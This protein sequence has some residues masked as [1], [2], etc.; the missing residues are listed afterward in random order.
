MRPFTF[1]DAALRVDR[2][3]ESLAT[4]KA[5]AS[6]RFARTLS[7]RLTR[8]VAPAEVV[9][10]NSD[11]PR[12]NYWLVTGRVDRM[13]QGSRLLRGLVGF[14]V[15]GTKIET[16]SV[17]SDLSGTNPKPFLVVET[18][19]GS[20]AARGAI[21]AAGYFVSG[22]T[23]LLSI[24]NMLESVRSGITFDTDRTTKEIAAAQSEFLYKQRAIPHEA[25]RAPKR[26]G[27]W[28][29]DFWPFRNAPEKLP[30]GSLTVTPA[31]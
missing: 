9:A 7:E 12:G 28:Q 16:T 25:A 17:V 27:K 3:G 29:P 10:A 6:A 20:N 21:G 19:G 23:S 1:N 2:S 18:T 31:E 8:H 24:G 13:N 15:G 30:E 11:L 26:P 5:D 22:I 14:G 4:F